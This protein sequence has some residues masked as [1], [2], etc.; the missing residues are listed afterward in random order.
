MNM[1]DLLI[2]CGIHTL[3]NGSD[4]DSY[5]KNT[6]KYSDGNRQND[7]HTSGL[8]SPD[9]LPRCKQY[10]TIYRYALRAVT[11]SNPRICGI[12]TTPEFSNTT[13]DVVLTDEL[14]ATVTDESDVNITVVETATRKGLT[15]KK[16]VA[17]NEGSTYWE[18]SFAELEDN[19]YIDWAASGNPVDAAA[20]ML[21]GYNIANDS[22]RYKQVPYASFHFNRTE[23]GF[24]L[25]FSAENPSG[26][27]VTP[28]WDF[29]EHTNS[30]KI[31]TQFQAYRLSRNYIPTDSTDAFNQG[32]VVISTKN[33]VRGRGRAISF[34]METEPTK[35]CQL[36]GWSLVLT[37]NTKV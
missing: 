34:K 1:R 10:H 4:H 22:M 6:G 14:G 35:D 5:H 31:G 27:L 24:N 26:C 8:V 12:Y 19:D 15:K 33:K 37:G 3:I 9:I 2:E 7:H 20:Y 29:A 36:L 13:E 17:L 23:T 32:N 30:G 28:Y 18:Y 16:Y 21:T 25:D 11:T